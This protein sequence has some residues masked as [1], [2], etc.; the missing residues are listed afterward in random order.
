M[1]T[2]SLGLLVSTIILA[3]AQLAGALPRHCARAVSPSHSLA[4]AG[5]LQKTDRTYEVVVFADD[6]HVLAV[7][8]RRRG[9]CAVA[10]F[11]RHSK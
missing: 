9:G 3:L 11:A 4:L 2:V 5:R 1:A 8:P 7:S 6:D 10:R